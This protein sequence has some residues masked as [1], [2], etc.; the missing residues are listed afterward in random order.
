MERNHRL[1]AEGHTEHFETMLLGIC[2]SV[3]R[4][5]WS[6]LGRADSNLPKTHCRILFAHSTGRRA[7]QHVARSEGMPPEKWAMTTWKNMG[8][9]TTE[10][11]KGD[12]TMA[13]HATGGVG[14][15]A[16]RP[17]CKFRLDAR[18]LSTVPFVF[19]RP[20]SLSDPSARHNIYS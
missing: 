2:S 5:L 8:G 7:A 18:L 1:L 17:K 3:Q 19:C 12:S 14:D 4:S 13:A 6:F 9:E 15:T 16:G 10:L 20:P 11:Q